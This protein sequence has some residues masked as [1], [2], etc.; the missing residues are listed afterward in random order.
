MTHSHLHRAAVAREESRRLC[1]LAVDQG[2]GDS[3][4]IGVSSALKV[5]SAQ[6]ASPRR[7]G[8]P[9]VAGPAARYDRFNTVVERCFPFHVSVAMNP[10]TLARRWLLLIGLALSAASPA[11]AVEIKLARH[12][13]YHEGRTVFSYLGD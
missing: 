11:A 2:Q 8:W 6:R 1:L 13:D 5:D 7:R 3:E 10:K 4:I 12:P 9:V